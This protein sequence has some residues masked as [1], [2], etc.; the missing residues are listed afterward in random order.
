MDKVQDL[1]LGI[2]ELHPLGLSPL[3]QLFQI[4]LKGLPTPR[5]INTFSQ[6]DVICKLTEGVINPLVQVNKHINKHIR[7]DGPQYQ[8]LGNTTCDR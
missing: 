2:V 5:L 1:V 3:I 4:A 6:H 7:Q 8:P